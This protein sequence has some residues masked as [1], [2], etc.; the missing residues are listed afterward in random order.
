MKRAWDEGPQGVA[1]EGVVFEDA[2]DENHGLVDGGRQ[3]DCVVV[4][5]VVLRADAGGDEGHKGKNVG[6]ASGVVLDAPAKRGEL[7]QH[8]LP[9]VKEGFEERG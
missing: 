9:K 5:W 8:A 4:V 7:G 6:D 2:L 3:G 1:A